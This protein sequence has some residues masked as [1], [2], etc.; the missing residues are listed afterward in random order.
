VLVAGDA[1]VLYVHGVPAAG[2][3]W[4]PFLARAGGVAPDL[5]GFGRTAKR[6]D[7]DY[8]I[9]GYDRWLEALCDELGLERFSL[10]VHDWGG[11]ALALAQRQ[12]E[13]IER[14]VL[15]SCVPLLPGYRWHRVARVWRTQVLGELAMGFATRRAF[16]R[17][18]PPEIAD[19]AFDEF[20]HATQRAAL[21]LYR[22]ASP[23][24][25]E[26]HGRRLGDLRCPALVLWATDD[27]YIAASFGPAY[28]DALGGEVELELTDGGHYTWLGRP[29]LVERVE[30]FLRQR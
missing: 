15:F 10:V 14:L 1:P 12:P 18:L 25:L 24:V 22:S 29:E 20:D 13:R 26:R 11:L 23:E 4:E 28:A 7:F 17:E 30:R 5:P 16:R 2:W 3:S 8:S 9:P 6:G 19:R 21:R 27:P